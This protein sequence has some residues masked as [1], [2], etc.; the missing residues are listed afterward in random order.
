MFTRTSEA[1]KSPTAM[2][3]NP[4]PSRRYML[5]KVNRATPLCAS[6]PTQ[7]TSS[8][9]TPLMS[10]LSGESPPSDVTIVSP[11]N[12]RAKYSGGPNDTA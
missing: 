10:P 3:M 5:S 9:S 6:I 2:P 8:P 4:T 11:M 7:A 1:A 12:V